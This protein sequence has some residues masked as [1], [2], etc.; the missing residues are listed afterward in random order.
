[1][2]NIDDIDR[3]IRKYISKY[4][5]QLEYALKE[6]ADMEGMESCL[7]ENPYTDYIV[8]AEKFMLSPVY[9]KGAWT[10]LLEEDAIEII[11]DAYEFFNRRSS[12]FK[13]LEQRQESLSKCINDLEAFKEV[14]VDM[15]SLKA[16]KFIAF[17]FGRMPVINFK[18]FEIYIY[19]R[20]DIIFIES[21]RDKSY[22][23][24][25][26]FVMSARKDKIDT[27]MSSLNFE[28]INMPF[29]YEEQIFLGT[30]LKA[31]NM[32]MDELEE[33]KKDI[34]FKHNETIYTFGINTMDVNNA[35]NTLKK[36]GSYYELR[37]YS[38]P[39]RF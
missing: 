31:Y 21:K 18:Q 17:R 23:Y 12:H 20:E 14:N 6:I 38:T 26:Y 36:A 4:E 34:S 13:Y 3:A 11:E 29:K 9:Q 30:P 25:V 24:G 16:L 28:K 1:M 35:Y 37:K 22:V 39:Q 2:G 5:I 7:S 33:V 10:E 8:K 27:V 32:M 19:D 15:P